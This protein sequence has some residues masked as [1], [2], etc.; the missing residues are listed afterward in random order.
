MLFN[1]KNVGAVK[2]LRLI[3]VDENQD[4]DK[5]IWIAA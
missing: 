1:I 4:E 2:I 3:R 5:I